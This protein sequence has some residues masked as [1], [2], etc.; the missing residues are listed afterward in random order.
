MRKTILY[1]AVL[2]LL[3]SCHSEETASPKNLAYL[4]N[5]F[6]GTGGHG[7]TYPGAASPFGFMQLSP[8]TRLT[9]WDGCGAYH[10]TDSILY[11]FS[12]T[13][14]SGTGISDYGDLLLMP[15]T[16]KGHFDN[17]SIKGVDQGY[18]SR[19]SHQSEQ[20]HAG[21]YQV[22]LR[23]YNIKAELTA[24]P[25]SG[26]HHYLFP[27]GEKP[28]LMIDLEHR[29]Q[30]SSFSL[31]I[32]DNQTLRGH[33]VSSAWAREQ[34]FYFYLE[35]SEAFTESSYNQDSTKLMLSFGD[36][37]ELFIKVGIS[38]VSTEGAQK[39]LAA[40]IPHWDFEQ[41]RKE[42]E[43]AWNKELS[44]IEVE[45]ARAEDDTIF[46]TAL[47]HSFLNPNIFYDVDGHYRGT[48]LKVHQSDSVKQYTLFSLWDTY[49]ASHPLYT[50]TQVEKTNHFINSFLNH[51]RDGGKLPMWEL[52][53]NYTG[54]MIGYHSVPVIVDAYVKG[55]RDF[56]AELALE[57]MLATANSDDLGKAY[58]RTFGYIASDEEH[59]SVSKNLEY[60][61]N[62][63]CIAQ[64]AKLLGK[65][66]IYEVFMERAQFY[67]NLFD[68]QTGFMRA[69]R[70]QMFLAPFDPS[71]V[72]F[73]F[74]EAN[75]W[76]YSFYAPQ[77]VSGLMRLHGGPAN[78]EAKLD[79]LFSASEATSGRKQA[80]ITGLI[81]QYAHGNEPSHH[82]AY[83]YNYS[84]ASAKT[85]AM[86]RRILKEMYR[87]APDGL[88]GNEDCGQMS[89]WYVLSALGFYP[90][91]PGSPIYTIGSPLLR[92]GRIKL[93][94]GNTFEIKV[95]NQ[96][97]ENPYIQSMSLN[98]TPYKNGWIDHETIMAGGEWKLTMGPKPGPS[99]VAP[100]SEIKE[101]LITP[102]PY[103]KNESGAFRDS[104][105]LSLHCADPEATIYYT[106]NSGNP[107]TTSMVYDKPIVIKNNRVISAIAYR[108]GKKMSK[109]AA[110][111]FVKLKTNR[112]MSYSQAPDP[113]YTGGGEAGLL[114]G[115][116]GGEDFR[117]GAW[118]GWQG[119]DLELIIEL[120]EEGENIGE[121]STSHMQDLKSWIL[122]PKEV[123]FYASRD[124]ENYE[125]LGSAQSETA[126]TAFGFIED[127]YRVHFSRRRAY[128]IK[129]EIDHYGPLPPGH[130]S[131]GEPSWLFMD[132]VFIR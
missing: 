84:G 105:V 111:V 119:E 98:G 44:K 94:N 66:S 67:Q 117:T 109:K 2:N 69:K 38:A 16:G 108:P 110:T 32:I 89:S 57:A 18:A 17:G 11:G 40:E 10:Y 52:A 19:F 43:A 53:G 50:I 127:K 95:A 130:I 59:E 5:P 81:G 73:N 4:V 14:L 20:A 112:K 100:V 121:I 29:D 90:V 1:L 116:D 47:Y 103:I 45:M 131:A 114:D 30:L 85:Q 9:G 55:I 91:N 28:G 31:E 24:A 25:R 58:Y 106:L 21:Y 49:R 92:E 75:S 51:Y 71:E 6:I 22:S 68:P 88:S 12:H 76:Q 124:G 41:L 113:Q 77:D 96:G 102:V 62:D 65:D 13:H 35:L 83:L 82:M 36:I 101:H 97:P 125:F 80:D 104:L 78:F 74:T 33:R 122:M 3:L 46:Y 87:N 70:K 48:D 129:I 120:G 128:F 118:Q 63:W 54:C 86:V 34:H 93:E 115:I 60:A 39:N 64:Y 107:D 99:L 15:Y 8:D 61:Y 126:D 27:N 79:A 72:N 42:T 7:H 23:D 132:E 37:E 26:M 123:R 56:D